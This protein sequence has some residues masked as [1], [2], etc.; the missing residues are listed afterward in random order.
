MAR[1][2]AGTGHLLVLMDT[3]GTVGTAVVGGIAGIAVAESAGD[4]AAA[5][6]PLG[7][8]G[9]APRELGVRCSLAFWAHVRQPGITRS[10]LRCTGQQ[11]TADIIVV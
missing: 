7:N 2:L 10:R 3:A 9:R 11:L 5:R 8:P 6:R 4:V 1:Y